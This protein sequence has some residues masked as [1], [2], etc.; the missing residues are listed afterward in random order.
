MGMGE[1]HMNAV[2]GRERGGRQSLNSWNMFQTMWWHGIFQCGTSNAATKS[3]SLLLLLC[4]VLFF[5][6][7]C[8]NLLTPCSSTLYKCVYCIYNTQ[9][10][11]RA[12]VFLSDCLCREPLSVSDRKRQSRSYPPSQWIQDH[13][14]LKSLPSA[15]RL[16]FLISS[17]QPP[18]SS[19]PLLSAASS[20]A[21]FSCSFFPP[22]RDFICSLIFSQFLLSSSI[23]SHLLL[24]SCITVSSRA[25]DHWSA[26]CAQPPLPPF[27]ISLVPLSVTPSFFFFFIA[28]GVTCAAAVS[29]AVVADDTGKTLPVWIMHWDYIKKISWSIWS[30]FNWNSFAC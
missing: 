16:P 15:C 11:R 23:L 4:F 18:Y 14:F 26:L 2:E 19:F 9:R 6:L 27:P 5:S 7:P 22:S 28:T 29:A 10:H 21:C 25:P 8:I 30:I 13:S 12:L 24:P 17:V 1:S 3:P 20:V